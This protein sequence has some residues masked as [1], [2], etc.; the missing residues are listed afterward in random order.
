MEQVESAGVNIAYT[1]DGGGPAVL[2]THGYAATSKMFAGNVPPLAVDHTVVRW[3][4]RG[5]GCSA[6]PAEQ[7]AY[8][9]ELAVGDM[10]AVLDAAGAASAVVAGH[11]LGG[12]LSLAFHIA[13]RERV[14]GLVLIDTGPGYRRPD[15]RAGWNEMAEGFARNLDLHGLDGHQGGD[16]FEPGAHRGGAAGLA[17]AARGILT[18]RDAAVIDSLPGIAVPVLVI[19]GSLDQPFLAGSQ[20]MAD[21]IPHAELVVVDGAGHAP[22]LT[23]PNVFDAALRRFLDR[24]A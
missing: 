6:A 14:R 10:A 4:V 1:V 18:Q 20:Y 7:S 2:F 23:H 21:R 3:D 13:H 9:A 19:V 16:E 5:H 8:S 11:S 22:N 12:F 17:G 24:V 15:A